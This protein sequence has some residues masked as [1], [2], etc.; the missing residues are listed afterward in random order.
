[1]TTPTI[2]IATDDPL[3]RSAYTL[4]FSKVPY[5]VLMAQDVG[6]AVQ[7]LECA[8]PQLI[9]LDIMMSWDCGIKVIQRIGRNCHRD[10]GHVVLVT[11]NPQRVPLIYRQQ[12]SSILTKP[13]CTTWLLR[14]VQELLQLGAPV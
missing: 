9:L 5:T 14:T 6:Q 4:A 2:L 3:L 13:V 11:D 12:C 8:H 7:I 1:M 10:D